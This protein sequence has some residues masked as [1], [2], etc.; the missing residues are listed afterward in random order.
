ME[1][2]LERGFISHQRH[3]LWL[4]CL[5]DPARNAFAAPVGLAGRPLYLRILH[6]LDTQFLAIDRQQ[7]D[8]YALN[9]VALLEHIN[10]LEEDLFL[11]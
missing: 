3:N 4:S 7:H 11:R 1:S 8:G 9:I 10:Y 6:R 5:E 2:P